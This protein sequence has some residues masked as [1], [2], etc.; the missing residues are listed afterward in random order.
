MS[1]SHE[2]NNWPAYPPMARGVMEAQAASSAPAGSPKKQKYF[3][4]P[5]WLQAKAKRLSAGN[6]G[7][8]GTSPNELFTVT[9]DRDRYT[10]DSR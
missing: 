1:S 4:D 3:T 9:M 6:A 5:K 7:L 10:L 8:A 2:V